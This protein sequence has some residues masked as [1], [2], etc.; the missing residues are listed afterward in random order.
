MERFKYLQEG[1]YGS[2]SP[3]S[4]F[5]CHKTDVSLFY[6]KPYKIQ[7]ISHLQY[8]NPW[9]CSM[10]SVGVAAAHTPG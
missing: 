4:P 9:G 6:Y 1:L 10:K 8:D 3:P 2:D 7:V 5:D